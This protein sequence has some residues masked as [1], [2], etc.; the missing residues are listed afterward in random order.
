ML[1]LIEYNLIDGGKVSVIKNEFLGQIS[2]S[3]LSIEKMGIGNT[4]HNASVDHSE[5]LAQRKHFDL[6][7]VHNETLYARTTG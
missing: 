3:S 4:A 7:A 1:E 6:Y 2:K 5:Q